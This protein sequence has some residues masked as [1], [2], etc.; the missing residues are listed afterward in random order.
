MRLVQNAL[1]A[2]VFGLFLVA[3]VVAQPL[4]SQETTE[5]AVVPQACQDCVFVGI[6]EGSWD[7]RA[8]TGALFVTI[9]CEQGNLRGTLR[10]FGTQTFGDD[11]KPLEKIKVSGQTLSFR[12][13]NTQYG[14]FDAEVD[15][16]TDGKVLS[17][18][19]WYR[20]FRYQV[21]LAK[22]Q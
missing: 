4:S 16:S 20:G 22:K 12:A 7:G 8:G 21:F 3:H 5:H 15:L 6:W 10:A 18:I 9:T 13:S 1:F 2:L 17:G 19:G 14:A 11:E